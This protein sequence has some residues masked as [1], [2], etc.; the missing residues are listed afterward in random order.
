MF[1]LALALPAVVLE[2]KSSTEALQ[3]SKELVKHNQSKVVGTV[4]GVSL[5][6]FLL[7]AVFGIF[8]HLGLAAASLAADGPVALVGEQLLGFAL[9][10]LYSIALVVLYYDLRIRYEGFDLELLSKEIGA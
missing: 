8:L 2:G 10:P 6:L 3:R 4:I 5:L 1:T 9:G 7:G